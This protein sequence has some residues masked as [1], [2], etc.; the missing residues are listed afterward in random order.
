MY[1]QGILY[2]SIHGTLFQ[3]FFI[4]TNLGLFFY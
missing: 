2:I 1:C 4:L 3:P